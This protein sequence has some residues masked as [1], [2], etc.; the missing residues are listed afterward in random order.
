MV[1]S[2]IGSIHYEGENY[3]EQQGIAQSAV[4]FFQ[5][6]LTAEHTVPSE[7]LLDFI[8]PVISSQDGD[9]LCTLPTMTELKDVVFS[10]HKDS[11]AGPDGFSSLFFQECWETIKDDLLEAVCDFWKGSSIPRNF[12]ATTIVLI[13]KNSSPTSW[14]EFR[15]ISL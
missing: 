7:R 6:L 3:T 13:P 2:W 15:P 9:Y 12:K 5:N 1:K 10:I 8:K 14:S 11:V 4:K